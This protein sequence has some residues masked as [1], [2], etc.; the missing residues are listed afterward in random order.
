M[1]PFSVSGGTAAAFVGTGIN[2]ETIGWVGTFV[3][4]SSGD[5]F[6][7][8]VTAGVAQE[9]LAKQMKAEPVETFTFKADGVAIYQLGNFG[10]A[11]KRLWPS[12]AGEPL[13]S[14]NEG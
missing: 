7:P 1:A 11:A 4:K 8:H 9:D 12:Q 2:P 10:T 5:H 6:V 14:W 13:P 3:P